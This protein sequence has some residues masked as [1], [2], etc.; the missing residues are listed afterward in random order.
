MDSFRTESV[1]TL[2]CACFFVGIGLLKFKA[3]SRRWAIAWIVLGYLICAI[4]LFGYFLAGHACTS[5]FHV[6]FG[7]EE[8]RGP[9]RFVLGSAIPLAF[10]V[11]LFW[12]HRTLRRPEIVALFQEVNPTREIEDGDAQ[13]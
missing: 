10:A 12:M 13:E 2:P 5:T 1:S 9:L 3:S 7:G 6:T 8:V 11:L 4:L